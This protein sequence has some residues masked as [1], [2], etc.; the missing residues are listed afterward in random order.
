MVN[1]K[2][3]S[4]I[5]STGFIGK[6]TLNVVDKQPWFKIEL[7]SCYR[8]IKELKKQI[9]KYKPSNIYIECKKAREKFKHYNIKYKFNIIEKKSELNDFISSD[10][11]DILVASSSGINS[12]DTVIA[13]LKKKKKICVAS[14]E[15]FLLYGKEIMKISKK[16]NNKIIPIDSE[17]SGVFQLL[18]SNRAEDVKKV[19]ITASG[20]PFY[21][22]KIKDLSKIKKEDA[23]NHPTWKMGDKITID[24]ATL[25]NKG[26]E[27]IEAATIFNIS[28]DKICPIIDKRSKI[29]S[30]V[31][32]IDGNY[33]FCASINDMRIPISYA[34]NYPDKINFKSKRTR[35]FLETLSLSEINEEDHKAFR[36]VRYALKKGGSAIAVLNAANN[37]A[38]NEFLEDRI[39]FMD[40]LNVVEKVIKNHTPIYNYKLN[41]ILD[42]YKNTENITRKICNKL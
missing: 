40:I 38:V 26:I 11:N 3:V 25:M 31:E 27:I 15:I 35:N 14:K 33:L 16:F 30:I 24:S 22:R 23:L 41:K 36:L 37:I 32:F 19:Y 39:K 42:I 18:E 9:S 7:L 34:L 13:A 2:R 20:G 8:N 10:S 12:I 6:Q 4:I 29:H 28:S 17:H 5:G 21:G 1:K